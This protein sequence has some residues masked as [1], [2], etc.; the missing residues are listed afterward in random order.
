M[1]T[2]KGKLDKLE[3][4]IESLSDRFNNGIQY[5]KKLNVYILVWTEKEIED[6][7]KEAHEICEK[8]GFVD[9]E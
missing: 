2:L 9:V 5:D 1:V 4:E 6:A 8:L 3:K 7:K